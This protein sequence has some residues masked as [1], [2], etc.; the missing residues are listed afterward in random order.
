MTGRAA[1][2]AAGHGFLPGWAI[3]ITGD[4][5]YFVVLMA[6]T[7]WLQASWAT[8]ASRSVRCCLS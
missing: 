1:A 5:I 7:L 3:A 4:M 8:S 2:K 6:S